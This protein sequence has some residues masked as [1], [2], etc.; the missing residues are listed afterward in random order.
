MRQASARLVAA[1]LLSGAVAIFGTVAGTV[2]G[3]SVVLAC[4]AFCAVGSGQVLVGN[5][6]DFTNPRTKIR[7][8]PATDGS[9]G[10]MYVGFDDLWPQG[11]MNEHG[12][13]FDGFAAPPIGDEG[14]AQLP[15]FPGNIIDKAMAE[16]RTVEE[17]VRLFSQY[18]RAFLREGILMFADAS[19]DAV[20]IERNAIVRKTRGHF[21]QTNFHQSRSRT[22]PQDGRFLTASAMLERAGDRISIDLFRS[23]LEATHQRGS[24]P[25]LYSNIYDLRARRMYLYFFHDFERVVT[26][27]LA[28]ELKKGARVL[29]IPALF[30]TNGDAEAFAAQRKRAGSPG[31]LATVALVAIPGILVLAMVFGAV[32]GGRSVRVGLSVLIATLVLAVGAVLG[33][34]SLHQPASTQWMEFSIGVASGQSAGIQPSVLRSDGITLKQAIAT[35]FDIPAVR[36]IGPPWL[37]E[38]AVRLNAVL[39]VDA[40]DSFKPLLQ[41]ELNKRLRLETHFERRPFDVFVLSAA[42]APRMAPAKGDSLTIRLGERNAEFRDATMA[43]AG[44]RVGVHPENAGDRRDRCR[45]C[46]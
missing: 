20:S 39:G 33:L 42:G 19:G 2:F 12:L 46:V 27:D 3:N 40:A 1:G 16:C 43:N 4:T 34:L 38:T 9:Y 29:D 30:P 41:Q 22:A 32:R 25:T 28:D 5:N 17:V 44:F 31:W 23:I 8:V 11:G 13:W 24:A 10:R 45:R 35:A 26:F 36:V 37:A 6:E 18:N 7:F 15:S 21:V 14:A